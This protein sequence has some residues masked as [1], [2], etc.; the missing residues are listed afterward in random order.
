LAGYF[1]NRRVWLVEA[2][3]APPRLAPYDLFL[4]Q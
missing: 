4:P 2:D 1:K 3:A